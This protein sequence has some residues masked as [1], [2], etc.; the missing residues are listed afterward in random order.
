MS[1]HHPGK[2]HGVERVEVSDDDCVMVP[3]PPKKP[4]TTAPSTQDSR[5]HT[6]SDKHQRQFVD[7]FKRCYLSNPKK[8]VFLTGVPGSGKSWILQHLRETMVNKAVDVFMREFQVDSD[9]DVTS[10]QRAEQMFPIA[11]P[12]AIAASNIKGAMN[13]HLLL[14]IIPQSK[15]DV[16]ALK[17]SPKG[18]ARILAM[19]VLFYDECSMLHPGLFVLVDRLFRQVRSNQSH[20]PFG[21]VMLVLSGDFFQLP[22]VSVAPD[23]M[24]ACLKLGHGQ[25]K[26]LLFQLELWKS[27]NLQNVVLSTPHRQNDDPTFALLQNQI[28]TNALSDRNLQLIKSRVMPRRV[29]VEDQCAR[30]PALDIP[31]PDTRLE[32]VESHI[33]DICFTNKSV[34]FAN[35]V[36]IKSCV[37]PTSSYECLLIESLESMTMRQF[38][39]AILNA[40]NECQVQLDAKSPLRWIRSYRNRG[41]GIENALKSVLY[42]ANKCG[43]RLDLKIGA[44]VVCNRN[45]ECGKVFNGSKG[46]IKYFATMKQWARSLKDL[47]SDE[48]DLELSVEEDLEAEDA[49]FNM[50]DLLSGDEEDARYPVV[51]FADGHTTLI[52]PIMQQL[53]VPESA[54]AKQGGEV[55]YYMLGLPLELAYAFTVHKQQGQTLNSIYITPSRSFSEPGHVYVALSRAKKL[56]HVGF[57]FFEESLINTDQRV[58]DFYAKLTQQ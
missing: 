28:R 26:P 29:F 7:T 30:S 27:L 52:T 37:G 53:T 44:R 50:K 38:K 5:V 22:Y 49:L 55:L 19:D 45:L 14:G 41:G 1:T 8:H 56:C 36:G 51:Q 32:F 9:A 16:N 18:T 33:T 4:T 23:N 39:L 10:R 12:T 43:W 13:L 24:M 48:E 46:F 57:E 11:T 54:G 34:D 20:L 47:K 15:G 42:A 6:S 58:V 2:R 21:G 3:P 31:Y 35:A 40:P 17:C 25:Q